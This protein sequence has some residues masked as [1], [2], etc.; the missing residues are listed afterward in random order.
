MDYGMWIAIVVGTI[1]ALLSKSSKKQHVQNQ[2]AGGIIIGR[3]VNQGVPLRWVTKYGLRYLTI[4]NCLG[5]LSAILGNYLIKNT[6]DGTWTS[7]M[8]IFMPVIYLC[9]MGCL[10][11]FIAPKHFF[12]NPSGLIHKSFVLI[13]GLCV[14]FWFII[15]TFIHWDFLTDL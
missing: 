14:F 3:P 1:I 9:I 6:V 4:T 7:L 12:Q 5:I 11:D 2:K 15:P 13:G 10:I 8:G